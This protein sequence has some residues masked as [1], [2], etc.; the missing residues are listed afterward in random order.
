MRLASAVRAT[1]LKILFIARAYPPTQGGME[2]L[3]LQLHNHL[4]E[5]V[6]IVSLINH[7][8]KKALPLF[9]PYAATAAVRQVRSGGFTSVHLADALLAPVGAAIKAATG[10]RVT[11]SVCG[12]DVT[13]ENEIYQR[14]ITNGLR[15]IDLA[16][17]ISAATEAAMHERTGPNPMSEVIPL[18]INPLPEPTTEA[19]QQFSK[20]AA[21]RE[22]ERVVLTVGRLIERKGVA[23]FVEHVLPRL[24]E[25]VTYC[26]IGVGAMKGEIER[27]AAIAGV[28]DRIRMLGSVTDSVLAAAYAS[29]DLFVMPNVPVTGDMEGFGLVALEAS[30]SGLPVLASNLDGIPEAIHH[31][32]NGVLVPPLDASAWAAEIRG[33]L[34]LPRQ[35]IVD[36][37]ARMRSYTLDNFGWGRTADRY[38]EA[39][40]GNV[41]ERTAA[42]AA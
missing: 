10:I 35:A 12:L 11:A 6:E 17:P 29:S 28:H 1:D 33:L 40:A 39:I 32:G 24:P 34:S 2:N 15:R 8:G 37:G 30:A 25:D 21:V 31:G 27:A 22:G 23:W 38:I 20:L 9:L 5:R 16:M 7:R 13:Y 3:A 19:R 4:E 36:A 42:R 41:E 14:V 26:I 18:G